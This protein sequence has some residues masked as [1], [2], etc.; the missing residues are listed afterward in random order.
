MKSLKKYKMIY[1]TI[2]K[3]SDYILAGHYWKIKVLDILIE[4]LFF[5]K[6]T[7]VVGI[8]YWKLY[9]GGITILIESYKS[10]DK[11]HKGTWKELYC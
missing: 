4:V 6:G 11:S 10:S 3:F 5:V 1:Y 2:T 7:I 8:F 9:L